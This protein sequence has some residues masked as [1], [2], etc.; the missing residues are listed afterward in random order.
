MAEIAAVIPCYKVTDQVLDVLAAIPDCFTRIYCVD[1]DCPDHSGDLIEKENRDPRVVVLRN[2]RNLGVGGAVKH[3]YR[4]A[5]E[6]GAEIILKIDGDGQ[7]DPRL[8]HKFIEPILSGRADYT[9]GN[10]F[11]DPHNIKDMPA[12]RLFGNAI[13]SFMNKF[14]SGYWH[15]FDPNNGYTAIHA[16]VLRLLPLDKLSDRY[17]FETDMLFRLNTVRAMVQD[18]PM[19]AVYG[20]EISNLN[21]RKVI[22]SFFGGHIRNF[23]KRVLY[24]YFLRDFHA[25]SAQLVLGLLLFPFGVAYGTIHWIEALATGQLTPTGI[26]MVAALPIIIGVQMLLSV[27]QFDVENTPKTVIH[28]LL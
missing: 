21:I 6:E 24:N 8:A 28:P 25:A 4:K 12:I 23:G 7:M 26:I 15:V 22:G 2:D 18:I 27:L 5:L 13:L 9:K 14:S 17:F 10:R 19:D 3:G 16:K 20:D 1:D 11:F